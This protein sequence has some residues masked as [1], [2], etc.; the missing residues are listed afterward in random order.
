MQFYRSSL[1][2]LATL[3]TVVLLISSV[4]GVMLDSAHV[5]SPLP[6]ETVTR[7]TTIVIKVSRWGMSLYVGGN[8]TVLNSDD[9]VVF[10]PV[11]I[12]D[13]GYHA[14]NLT[15]LGLGDHKIVLTHG[16]S[17]FNYHTLVRNVYY[18]TQTVPFTVV[19]EGVHDQSNATDVSIPA[20]REK[21]IDGDEVE[22]NSAGVNIRVGLGLFTIVSCVVV[23][24]LV[25]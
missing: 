22:T 20:S 17:L 11:D 5:I 18:S 8:Y 9:V 16:Q 3:A 6:G 7:D 12:V 1:Q 25:Q 15:V 2:T 10:G 23:A 19:E 21:L 24:M 13:Y 14:Q 4:T